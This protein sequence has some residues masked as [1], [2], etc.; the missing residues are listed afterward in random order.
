M[1]KKILIGALA[2]IVITAIGFSVYNVLA[3]GTNQSASAPV[4][5]QPPVEQGQQGSGLGQQQG[6]GQGKG[7]GS[8]IPNSQNGLTEWTTVQGVVSNYAAPNFTLTTADGQVL[9]IQLGNLNYVNSLGLIMKDGDSIT[10]TGFYDPSGAFAVGT[11]TLDATGQTF[12]L[13]DEYGRPAWRGGG[14]GSTGNF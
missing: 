8:G 2:A 13:R 9:A 10:L 14:G 6:Q 12:T 3:K 4:A 5:T 1:F 7:Q 11:L